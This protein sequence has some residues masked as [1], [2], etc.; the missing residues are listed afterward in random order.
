MVSQSE[1]SGPAHDAAGAGAAAPRTGRLPRAERREQILVA[2]TSAFADG[3]YQATSLDDVAERAGI[4]RMIVYR[5]F[6]SKRDLYLAVL[7]R[8]VER[9]LAATGTPQ[10]D[11]N[12]IHGLLV[13]A[14][15]DPDGFRLV[16]RHT[17]REPEFKGHVDRFRNDVFAVTRPHLAELIPDVQWADWASILVPAAVIEAVIAWLD[18]G[19]PEPTR[20]A[21]RVERLVQGIV[22]AACITAPE[23]P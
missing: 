11:E 8:V 4:S 16:F 17:A 5:H 2:A 15:D 3:G 19:Q 1:S 7:D 23:H 20:A 9:L 12:S 22:E 10:F 13:A 21:A 18:V 14:A 6:D